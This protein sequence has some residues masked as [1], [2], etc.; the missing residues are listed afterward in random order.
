MSALY[1]SGLGGCTSS[2]RRSGGSCCSSDRTRRQQAHANSRSFR[3]LALPRKNS[4]TGCGAVHSRHS[5]SVTASLL[6]LVHPRRDG[7]GKTEERA[8]LLQ[9]AVELSRSSPAFAIVFPPNFLIERF[10]KGHHGLLVRR[11]I[12]ER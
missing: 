12:Q 9:D 7:T 6:L 1:S 8:D 3:A 5:A 10:N 2:R 4:S 11:L